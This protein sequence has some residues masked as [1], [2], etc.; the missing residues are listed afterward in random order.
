MTKIKLDTDL[1]TRCEGCFEPVQPE[2]RKVV[3]GTSDGQLA[4]FCTDCARRLEVEMVR[5][6]F[7]DLGDFSKRN[8]ISLIAPQGESPE[9]VTRLGQYLLGAALVNDTFR[10]LVDAAIK[11]TTNQKELFAQGFYLGVA[12]AVAELHKGNLSK[13]NKG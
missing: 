7:V 4:L 9:D 12:T 5:H 10:T 8:I 3:F 13:M 6:M 11:E 2:D 1:A